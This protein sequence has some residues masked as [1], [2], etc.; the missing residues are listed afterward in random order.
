MWRL[1]LLADRGIASAELG[2]VG[3]RESGRA[4]VLAGNC[5]WALW[6]AA[7]VIALSH[8]RKRALSDGDDLVYDYG[9]VSPRRE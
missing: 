4:R 9:S 8:G 2:V 7:Y 1:S 6:A 5:W 3:F